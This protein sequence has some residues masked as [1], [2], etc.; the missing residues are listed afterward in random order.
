MFC[1]PK[2]MLVCTIA[3]VLSITVGLHW[4]QTDN[5]QI[6]AFLLNDMDK[7]ADGCISKDEANPLLKQ[8]FD[9]FDK[10]TD[11]KIDA[12]ELPALATVVARLQ[13]GQ[14]QNRNNRR[15]QRK[16]VVPDS[17][18]RIVD[19]EYR[20]GT[21]KRWK[22]DLVHPKAK[23][24]SPRPAIV[25]IH[26][27]GWRNGD[28]GWGAFGSMPIEYAEKGYVCISVNY[29]FIDEAPFP[30]CIE[31]CKNA[32]RW[33]RANAETYNVDPDHIGAFGISAGAHLVSMLGLVKKERELEGDGPHLEYS[34]AVTSVCCAAPPTN[35]LKWNGEEV[36]VS[37][38]G[39]GLKQVFGA[40]TGN[41]LKEMAEKSAPITYV[42]SGAVPFLVIH[43]TADKTVPV[44]QGD[45]FAKALKDVGADVTYLRYDGAGHG[46]FHQKSDKTGPALEKF[47][48]RTL[49][50]QTTEP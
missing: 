9:R 40:K 24:E 25:F 3:V 19:I 12:K 30:A 7:D 21:S 47:F 34:S 26:G 38:M 5:K 13:R 43:G 41:E 28:K 31:D 45:C 20:K 6:I 35:F 29:R 17:V 23:S 33:L 15:R 10:D 8:H 39:W 4:Q 44:F 46:V 16:L 32:V 1:C 22:L 14:N 2:L 27:G 36:D 50:Q 37:K 18:N 42:Q 48:Q 11:G 49:G